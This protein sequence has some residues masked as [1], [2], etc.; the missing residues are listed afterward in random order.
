[1]RADTPPPRSIPVLRDVY[2]MGDADWIN[3]ALAD[4]TALSAVRVY[5]GYSG[6]APGQLRNEVERGGWNILPADSET[7]FDKNPSEVWLELVKRAVLRPSTV[8]HND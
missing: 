8:I 6:W 4:A 3:S 5:A 2:L 1:M 7:I